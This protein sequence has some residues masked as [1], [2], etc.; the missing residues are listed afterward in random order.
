MEL[1]F[2]D[3]DEAFRHDARTWLAANIPRTRCPAGGPDARTFAT[4]WLKRLHAAGWSGISWPQEYRRERPVACP[5]DHLARGICVVGRPVAAGPHL[6]RPQSR[7]PDIDRLRNAGAEDVSPAQNP[8]RRCDLVPGFL[9][10][11]R[12]IRSREHHHIRPDRR[13]RARRER[14]QDL[15]ELRRY[16]RLPGAARAHRARREGQQGAQLGDLRHEGA[17]HHHPADPEPRRRPVISARCSTTT[18]A[19]RSI[20]SSG[21]SGDGWH[22]AMTTLGFERGTAAIA[23]QLALLRKVDI[24]LAVG[25]RT[26]RA[27]RV[28]PDAAPRARSRRSPRPAGPD[29]PIAVPPTRER[30]RG[31][32]RPAVLC[33][34]RAAHSPDR[35]GPARGR[36]RGLRPRRT[37]GRGLSRSPSAKPSRAA[38]PKFSATSSASG[39]SGSRGNRAHDR[40][41]QSELRTS[42]QIVD[43]V[44]EVLAGHVS[45]VAVSESPAVMAATPKH[46]PGS[47][48]SAGSASASM[49]PTAAPG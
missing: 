38:R 26:R 12:R 40:R 21:R 41:S 17:R 33:R 6:R 29:L 43:A 37:L 19:S 4:D 22:V 9:R 49:K 11:Q 10:A 35:H 24:L 32:D 20:R 31:I 1:R 7:R 36:Q 39:C 46:L 15:D 47:R 16:R 18:C 2:T 48:R 42:E 8:R 45:A 34:A 13:G 28:R 27:G 5:P 23:L 3:A 14:P 25:R 30:L 44:R